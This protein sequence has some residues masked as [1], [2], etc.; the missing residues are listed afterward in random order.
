MAK[1]YVMTINRTLSNQPN[2]KY[3][4]AFGGSASPP[5][6]DMVLVGIPNP[7]L[8]TLAK[9]L[10]NIDQPLQPPWHVVPGLTEK[11]PAKPE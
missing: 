7:V 6:G 2:A 9:R 3:A 10:G 8:R 11:F 5:G 1:M 4:G